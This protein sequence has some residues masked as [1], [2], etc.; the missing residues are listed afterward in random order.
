MNVESDGL[1]SIRPLETMDIL[2]FSCFL[3]AFGIGITGSSELTLVRVAEQLI[4]RCPKSTLSVRIIPRQV[5]V[6]RPVVV[7]EDYNQWTVPRLSRW[8]A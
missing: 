8:S 4:A 7:R 1:Q 5:L 3:D 6:R 2:D